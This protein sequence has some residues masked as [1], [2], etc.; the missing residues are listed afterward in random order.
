MLQPWYNLIKTSINGG[1]HISWKAVINSVNAE[2]DIHKQID[3]PWLRGSVLTS[4]R[5]SS[6]INQLHT[7]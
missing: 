3:L 5:P 2:T 4:F 7:R 1:T 6:P